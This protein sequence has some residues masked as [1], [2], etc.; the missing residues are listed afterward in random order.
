[1]IVCTFNKKKKKL[2]ISSTSDNYRR[3]NVYEYWYMFVIFIIWRRNGRASSELAKLPG[4]E[5][6]R[7]R[8]STESSQNLFSWNE[9]LHTQSG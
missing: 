6:A 3:S 1:M 9:C 5:I 7:V 4:I 8:Y 2:N